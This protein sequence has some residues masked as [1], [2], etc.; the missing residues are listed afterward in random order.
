MGVAT[1]LSAPFCLPPHNSESLKNKAE[2]CISK[3]ESLC[4]DGCFIKI[5]HRPEWR[6]E[7]RANKG[8]PPKVGSSSPLSLHDLLI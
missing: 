5:A 8:A 7:E 4:V 6:R 2:L 3:A 1:I